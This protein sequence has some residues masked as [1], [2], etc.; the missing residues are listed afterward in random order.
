MS[1]IR[2]KLANHVGDHVVLSPE[3]VVLVTSPGTASS[4]PRPPQSLKV[5]GEIRTRYSLVSGQCRLHGSFRSE[6]EIGFRSEIVF[7]LS[8]N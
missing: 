3:R 6:M 4:Y 2:G 5:G 1:S 7:K 8:R